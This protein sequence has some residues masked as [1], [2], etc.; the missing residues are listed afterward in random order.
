[1]QVVAENFMLSVDDLKGRSRKQRVVDARAAF[2]RLMSHEFDIPVRISAEALRRTHY[3]GT[4][5]SY[6]GDQMMSERMWRS[7]YSECVYQATKGRSE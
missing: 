3:M 6:I 7:A 4:H 5:Y 2:V 1:M